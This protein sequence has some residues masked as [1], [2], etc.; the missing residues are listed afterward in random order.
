M[1]HRHAPLQT[2]RRQSALYL[3]T[4]L[5]PDRFAF[6][7]DPLIAHDFNNRGFLPPQRPNNRFSTPTTSELKS[8]TAKI[9]AHACQPIGAVWKAALRG[10]Q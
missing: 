7:V 10:G 3:S 5:L 9:S 8:A 1:T 4:Q 2:H 6:A